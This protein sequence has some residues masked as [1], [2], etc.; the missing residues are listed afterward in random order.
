MPIHRIV[1]KI[2]DYIVPT[3]PTQ[4]NL[5]LLA[6]GLEQYIRTCSHPSYSKFQVS[7]QLIPTYRSSLRVP[8]RYPP[9]PSRLLL[10]LHHRFHCKHR[11]CPSYSQIP[12]PLIPTYRSSLPRHLRGLLPAWLLLPLRHR[13]AARPLTRILLPLRHRFVARLFTQ[14]LLP[15]CHRFYR[16]TPFHSSHS[17]PTFPASSARRDTSHSTSTSPASSVSSLLRDLF[18]L[19]F[20]ISCTICSP[21]RLP[22]GFYFPCIIGSLQGLPLGFYFPCVIGSPRRL[23]LGFYFPSVTGSLRRLPLGFYFPHVIGLS[24]DSSHVTGGGHRL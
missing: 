3:V 7:C 20:Y 24:R 18:P 1:P 13:F 12:S 21:R 6:L 5:T 19:G 10:P 23:P 17:A 4:L 11:T 14:L 2:V 15:L 9:I 16:E 22:L 8:P